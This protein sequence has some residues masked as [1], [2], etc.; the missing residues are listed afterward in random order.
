MVWKIFAVFMAGSFGFGLLSNDAN[1]DAI[2]LIS[3]PISAVANIGLIAYAF[4]ITRLET[5]YWMPFGWLLA[6]WS[7]FTLALLAFR[8]SSM[9]SPIWAIFIGGVIGAAVLYFQWLA[10]YRLGRFSRPSASDGIV[11]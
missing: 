5:R 7:V 9:S 8:G 6:L 11:G 4:G 2:Y 10:V 3:T 1:R